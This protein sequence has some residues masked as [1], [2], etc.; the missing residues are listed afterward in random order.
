MAEVV[1]LYQFPRPKTVANLS[2]FCLKV[3]TFMRIASIPYE[4]EAVLNPAIAPKGRLPYITHQGQNIPDSSHIIEYLKSQFSITI[5]DDLSAEQIAIGHSI[6]IMLEERLR[7]CIVYSRW[8]DD[9][10]VPTF[11]NMLRDFI[12]FPLSVIFP[13]LLRQSK[14]RITTTLNSNGIGEFTPAEI[15]TF[16]QKDLEA[17]ITILGNKSYLFGDKPSSY[18]AVVYAFLANLIDVPLECP[19]NTFARDR[20][21]LCNYCQRIKSNYF[22]D[23]DLIV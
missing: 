3:E 21:T 13:L 23:L 8:I 20:E 17:L 7:W 2:F 14:K 12:P 9:R 16:G 4:V 1:T 15:Y 6:S 11:K 18:D 19:L 5:D 22:S 10:Y